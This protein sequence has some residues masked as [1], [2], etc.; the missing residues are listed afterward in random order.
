MYSQ[1]VELELLSSTHAVLYKLAQWCVNI[2][3]RA[4]ST[5]GQRKVWQQQ[6][7]TLHGIL[8]AKKAAAQY[9]VPLTTLWRRLSS[10]N[11]P[12]AAARKLLGRF[13]TVFFGRTREGAGR[14]YL[15]DGK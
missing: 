2:S 1:S 15:R 7:K 14:L 10:N 9:H 3:A 8:S 4:S 11:E 5:L 6:Y 13:R 12:F